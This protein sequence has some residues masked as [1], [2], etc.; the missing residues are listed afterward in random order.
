LTFSPEAAAYLAWFCPA[1]K[2]FLD[3]RWPLYDRVA[4]DFVAMR[5]CLLEPNDSG[6]DRELGPLLDA[7]Q[8]DRIILHDPDFARTTKAYRCL[9]QGGEEWEL[10]DI[11][12]TAALFG[13]RSRSESPSPWKALDRRREAYHPE[14][15]RR[16]PLDASR[17]PQPPGPFDPF[18][19]ERNDR[20][21]ERGE[22]ALHL[23]YFDLR[24]E[25]MRADLRTQWLLAQA[26]G[27][28][29]SGAAREPAGTAIGLALRLSL[30]ALLPNRGPPEALLL[31]IRAARRALAANPDDASAFLLLGEAYLRLGRQTEEGNWQ[32]A[33]PALADIRNAQTLT[34]L[35]QAVL[36]R[37]D[38]DRAH[39]LLAQLYDEAGQMDRAL[40]HMRA[41]LRIAEAE[42]KK[43]GPGA[44][45]AAE[46]RDAREADVEAKESLVRKAQAIYEANTQGRTDPSQ[47]VDRARL[48]W[49]HGL[50]R[51]AL[52]M[53]LD[54][55]PAIFGKSGAELQLDL[56]LESGRAFEV[57][58]WLEPEH[59]A[60]LGFSSYHSLQARAAAACGDYA[61]ADAEL[62]KLG[63]PLRQIQ[64]SPEQ[65]VPVRS[66][67]AL[68]VGGAVLARLAFGSGPAG[69][70]GMAY[71]QFDALRPLEGLAE[72][73][74]QEADLRVLRGLLAVE[75]GDVESAR[76]HFR[77]ALEVW[78]SDS[79]AATGAGV[80]FRTRPIAQQ[81]IR[82]LEDK[83]EK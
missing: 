11:E 70:A 41:R 48:A 10:L 36:L 61:A 25:R 78:G 34:A 39:E 21:A 69:L 40:D 5:R 79:Q 54:S 46:R 53:L 49:R 38:L 73:L 20:S 22:A 59:E 82:L 32:A 64:T 60:V 50:S 83:D 24:V 35:E 26:T 3:S 12:G 19:R 4:D 66:A 7:H 8:I 72:L 15:E 18:F 75:S 23:V 57:R 67:V 27:L 13:R 62:D 31:A 37:P 55:H 47:V 16:A 52:E 51:K 44:A 30:T 77:A 71:R 6:P 74:G 28:V 9:L 17:M 65:L 76:Q 56:M 14:P 68:R 1:E 80:D 33:L 29:G 2:G 45:S 81:A 42:V 43:Q 58:A 63:E